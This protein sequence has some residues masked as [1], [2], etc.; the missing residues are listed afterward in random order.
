[1]VTSHTDDALGCCPRCGAA[2]A[3]ASL[4]IRYQTADGDAVFA[5]CPDCEEPVHPAR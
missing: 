2:L 1:M 3:A 4:L 5:E